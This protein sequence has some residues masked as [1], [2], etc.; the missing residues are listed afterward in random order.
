MLTKIRKMIERDIK[1]RGGG[2]KKNGGRECKIYAI[3]R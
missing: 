1:H 2:E 3:L